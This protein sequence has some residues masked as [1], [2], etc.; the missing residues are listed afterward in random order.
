[1][2]ILGLYF[3]MCVCMH[4][5]LYVYLCAKFSIGTKITVVPGVLKGMQ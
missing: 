4:S 5:C 3:A 2:H 1:M